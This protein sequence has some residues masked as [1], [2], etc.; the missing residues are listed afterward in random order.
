MR[1]PEIPQE[2]P[3]SIEE[4]SE[5]ESKL[6]SA[7]ET[8]TTE[9]ED[10]VLPGTLLDITGKVVE[11]EQI[12]TT[13]RFAEDDTLI[14]EC[15]EEDQFLVKSYLISEDRA[16]PGDDIEL[17][18]PNSLDRQI[19]L[20]DGSLLSISEDQTQ[21][22]HQ[23]QTGVATVILDGTLSTPP[24]TYWIVTARGK[25]GAVSANAQEGEPGCYILNLEQDTA[26]KLQISGTVIP[27]DIEGDLILFVRTSSLNPA[28]GTKLY[29]YNA[30]KNDLQEWDMGTEAGA[31][32][33]V[34]SNG[35]KFLL[36]CDQWDEEN[37]IHHFRIYDTQNGA[38]I[39]DFQLN[40]IYHLAESTFQRMAINADGSMVALI[41]YTSY[42]DFTPHVLLYRIS[43]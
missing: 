20:K 38:E 35:G 28:D 31:C 13:I 24:E 27:S 17:A 6:T 12:P 32:C 8:S 7:N 29:C 10:P 39:Q 22:I 9:T 43:S 15:L 41:A 40:Q 1:S 21:V 16:E 4:I 3:S 18:R 5:S 33:A 14:V 23:N 11:G 26:Q 37:A 42:Q 25:W 2:E 30:A 19:F 36:S 34:L